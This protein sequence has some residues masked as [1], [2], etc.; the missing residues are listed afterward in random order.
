MNSVLTFSC[1][2]RYCTINI[3]QIWL[4][5]T[6]LQQKLMSNKT[7]GNTPLR[8]TTHISP[9]LITRQSTLFGIQYVLFPNIS[10]HIYFLHIHILYVLL[11][12]PDIFMNKCISSLL[13]GKYF[14]RIILIYKMEINGNISFA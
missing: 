12:N 8:P 4:S 7:K 2:K 13:N 10:L 9:P 14:I 1:T 5:S 3:K 6:P 11:K